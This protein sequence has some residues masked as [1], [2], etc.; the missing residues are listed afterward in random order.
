METLYAQYGLKFRLDQ[1]RIRFMIYI[2]KYN[3]VW[4]LHLRVVPS[5][6][7]PFENVVYSQKS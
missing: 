5:N 2:L 1:L 7:A 3:I 4:I 6:G